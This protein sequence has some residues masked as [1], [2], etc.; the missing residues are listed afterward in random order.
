MK[1][2]IDSTFFVSDNYVDLYKDKL[3]LLEFYFK[4]LNN[5]KEKVKIIFENYLVHFLYLKIKDL[6]HPI[7]IKNNTTIPYAIFINYF[8]YAL[9]GITQSWIFNANN[10]IEEIIKITSNL[11]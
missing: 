6:F 10:S 1:Y 8:S 9:L 7:L 11:M 4:T 3:Q 2:Y 5:E